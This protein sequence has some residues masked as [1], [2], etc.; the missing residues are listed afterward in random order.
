MIK[1]IECH[2]CGND[3]KIKDKYDEIE[4]SDLKYCPFCGSDNITVDINRRTGE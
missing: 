1:T 3:L 2:E 4:L